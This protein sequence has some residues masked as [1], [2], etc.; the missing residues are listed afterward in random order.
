MIKIIYNFTEYIL[1]V[2]VQKWMT[3]L[4]FV[5]NYLSM[6]HFYLSN[7]TFYKKVSFLEITL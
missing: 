2:N 3:P 7:I 4:S 5:Y 6:S 1:I